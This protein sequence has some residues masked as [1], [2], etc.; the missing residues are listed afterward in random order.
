MVSET[1]DNNARASKSAGAVGSM[2]VLDRVRARKSE[3]ADRQE[4]TLTDVASAI[5][6]ASEAASQDTPDATTQPQQP[7]AEDGATMSSKRNSLAR[8]IEETREELK[9]ANANVVSISRAAKQVGERRA[10]R[11][12]KIAETLDR[13]DQLLVAMREAQG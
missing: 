1:R 8:S 7:A 9:L 3:I 2:S 4:A 10:E 13:A 6:A 12:K 11:R 5:A